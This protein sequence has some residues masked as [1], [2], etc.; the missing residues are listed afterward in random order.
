MSNMCMSC[1]KAIF[2][3]LWGEYRCLAKQHIIYTMP[4]ECSDYKPLLEDEKVPIAKDTQNYM[5]DIDE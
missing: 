1:K 4:L 2:D 5:E 3:P